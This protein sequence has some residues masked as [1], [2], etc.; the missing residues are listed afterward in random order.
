M[1]FPV[2]Q[3]PKPA[4]LKR[5]RA[6]R[7]AM[8]EAETRLWRALRRR[9]P[10]YHFRRQVPIDTFIADFC[11]YQARLVVEVDGNQHGFDGARARDARRTAILESKGFRV[12]R[13]SNAD[14]YNAIDSVLD[15]ILAHLEGRAE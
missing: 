3:P 4:L 11:C 7:R 10:T 15:T 9:M 6:M 12:I 13:F 8:T 14:V 2:Y 1:V 5:A